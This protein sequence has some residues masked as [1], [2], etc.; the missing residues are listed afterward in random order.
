VKDKLVRILA[1]ILESNPLLEMAVSRYKTKEK[2]GELADPLGNEILKLYLFQHSRN[3]NHWGSEVRGY[4]RA[5]IKKKPKGGKFSSKDYMEMLWEGPFETQEE[6]KDYVLDLYD[7]KYPSYNP[8]NYYN[9]ENKEDL[10]RLY[11]NLKQ[12]YIE[13]CQ[14]LVDGKLQNIE[15]YIKYD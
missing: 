11:N 8:S 12:T 6:V 13:I 2:I 4:L 10:K 1:E 7:G 5:I 9:I 14:D 3:Q 15:N